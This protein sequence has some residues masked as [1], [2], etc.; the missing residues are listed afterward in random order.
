MIRR[1]VIL[2]LVLLLAVGLA[3]GMTAQTESPIHQVVRDE[4]RFDFGFMPDQAEVTH[5]FWLHNRSTDSIRVESV[6]PGCGCLT[7]PFAADALAPQDSVPLAITFHSGRFKN[8]IEKKTRVTTRSITTDV[9]QITVLTITGS[10]HPD[11]E[12]AR[13][14]PAGL[15]VTRLRISPDSFGDYLT[16]NKAAKMRENCRFDPLEFPAGF[17]VSWMTVDGS[18]VLVLAM[19]VDS[20]PP[21]PTG[22]LTLSVDCDSAYN[23]TIPIEVTD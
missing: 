17:R 20:L 12:F 6:K 10:V 15:P 13:Y 14:L 1:L 8:H 4:L 11:E 9:A 16:L 5:T 22:S 18:S 21:G 3:V 7:A 23:V 19:L 2:L